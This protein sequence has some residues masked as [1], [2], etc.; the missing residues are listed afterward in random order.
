MWWRL[1]SDVGRGA[2]STLGGVAT[3]QAEI[4][5][6][7]TIVWRIVREVDAAGVAIGELVRWGDEEWRAVGRRCVRDGYEPSELTR[8]QVVGV[9]MERTRPK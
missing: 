2:A 4:Q 5:N 7:A 6:R 9:M 8:G 1:L 3:S